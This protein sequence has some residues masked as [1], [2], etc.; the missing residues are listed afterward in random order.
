MTLLTQT[1]THA[2][3]QRCSQAVSQSLSVFPEVMSVCCTVSE[4][5][6][7]GRFAAAGV[8]LAEAEH[9]DNL[10][11]A[12]CSPHLS[13]DRFR[14]AQH[15]VQMNEAVAPKSFVWMRGEEACSYRFICFPTLEIEMLRV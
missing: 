2:C 5:H 4:I 9:A 7:S 13:A 1:H 6:Y 12:L 10:P 14:A 3:M 8:F 11:K 15:P